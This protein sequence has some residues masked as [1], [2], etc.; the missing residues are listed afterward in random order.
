MKT[1]PPI[2]CLHHHGSLSRRQFFGTTAAALGAA[3]SDCPARPRWQSPRQCPTEPDSRRRIT[4]R[5]VDPS[6][7]DSVTFVMACFFKY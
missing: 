7:P 6:L 5:R 1:G 3:L 4:L 2:R